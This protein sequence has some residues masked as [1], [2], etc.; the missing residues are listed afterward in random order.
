MTN[1]GFILQEKDAQFEVRISELYKKNDY[2]GIV[3]LCPPDADL[4]D[5]QPLKTR[6]EVVWAWHHNLKALEQNGKIRPQMAWSVRNE[7]LMVLGRATADFR[8]H[9]SL[10]DIE[11][12]YPIVFVDENRINDA[13]KTYNR[14][15][16][17]YPDNG[18]LMTDAVILLVKQKNFQKALTIAI[19]ARGLE[20]SSQFPPLSVEALRHR[21]F[22]GNLARWIA[23]CAKEIY[24]VKCGI[25]WM[26][27]AIQDWQDSEGAGWSAKNHI[28][29]ANKM[30]Q[31]WSLLKAK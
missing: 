7:M 28:D 24:G 14:L 1:G 10:L 12:V 2:V 21:R 15:L 25:G 11:K 5:G 9:P 16:E 22:A 20:L 6:T 23:I 8:N 26:Q 18:D 19:Q 31:E 29:G 27:Q 30:I 3:K 13:I 4:L 17:K